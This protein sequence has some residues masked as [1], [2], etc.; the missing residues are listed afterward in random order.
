M[1]VFYHT[2][3]VVPIYFTFNMENIMGENP[4]SYVNIDIQPQ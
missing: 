1:D 4:I 2:T 3:L